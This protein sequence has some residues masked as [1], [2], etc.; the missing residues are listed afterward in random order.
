MDGLV[1]PFSSREQKGMMLSRSDRLY[2]ICTQL[3]SKVTEFAYSCVTYVNIE[4]GTQE[5]DDV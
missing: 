4:N 1:T 2:I 3:K 5:K